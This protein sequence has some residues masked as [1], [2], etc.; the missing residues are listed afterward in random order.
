[1]INSKYKLSSR[2]DYI[3]NE[4]KL[5]LFFNFFGSVGVLWTII[6]CLSYLIQN[7]KNSTEGNIFV[8]LIVI[9]VSLAYS[10]TVTL[11][12]MVI[13]RNFTNL[14]TSFRIEVGN[15]LDKSGN[16]IIASSNYFDTRTS[17]TQSLKTQLINK[18]FNNS[19]DLLDRLIQDNLN[20]Q[21]ITGKSVDVIEKPNGKRIKY[22]IGTVADIQLPSRPNT[23]IFI[24][25]ICEIIYN[26][27]IKSKRSDFRMLS[28]ALEKTWEH[29]RN[30][31]NDEDIYIP[32]LGAGVTG[33]SLSKATLIQLIVFSFL[34]N[35]KERRIGKSLNIIIPDDNY[36][37][38]LFEEINNH[39]Q[40]FKV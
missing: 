1:M 30:T 27:Q 25:V 4:R 38:K 40:T 18:Y 5:K 24:T 21:G 11:P 12:Q 17:K 36:D 16:L 26:G 14:N 39:I 15:L 3:F 6:E 10:I 23:R 33:L 20:T 32:I 37:P 19:I 29:I 28:K 9:C 34:L 13:S 7:F 8:L 35:S 2:L 31:N 22:E